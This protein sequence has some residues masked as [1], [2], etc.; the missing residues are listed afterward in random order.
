MRRF[1]L[2][3]TVTALVCSFAVSAQTPAASKSAG[4]AA[5]QPVPEMERASAEEI[6]ALFESMHIK[7]QM[8]TVMTTMQA[9]MNNMFSE[10][11][12]KQSPPPS[13]KLMTE[14]RAMMDESSKIVN[15]GELLDDMV[16]IYQKYL[17]RDEIA[18]IRMFY[19]SPAGKSLLAKSP[20]IGQEFMHEVMPKEMKKMQAEM[21]RMQ[22]RMMKVMTEQV[23]SQHTK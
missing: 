1:V 15:I 4:P 2:L 9:Q 20:V 21:E 12:K 13:P 3:V 7:Q 19:E 6:K 16:P 18:S 22:Q 5:I 14:V 10:M 23:E 17:T 11:V 8:E